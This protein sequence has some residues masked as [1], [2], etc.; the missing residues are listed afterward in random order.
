MI[1]KSAENKYTLWDYGEW[2]KIFLGKNLNEFHLRELANNAIKLLNLNFAIEED[3]N[4]FYYIHEIA[5][6][7]EKQKD[8]FGNWNNALEKTY[9]KQ[10]KS[11]L[12]NS[13]SKKD[14]KDVIDDII[15]DIADSHESFSD[16]NPE[17]YHCLWNINSFRQLIKTILIELLNS[18]TP[19]EYALIELKEDFNTELDNFFDAY[20]DLIDTFIVSGKKYKSV[21]EFS[22][23]SEVGK[24]FFLWDTV[25]AHI[26]I[27]FL[28]LG[29]QEYFGFCNYCGEFYIVHRKGKKIYCK[30]TCRAL[31]SREARMKKSK[32]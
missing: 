5:K 7:L 14:S 16:L 27:N 10:Q 8:I 23:N 25:I 2:L 28:S 11:Q 24:F 17:K 19:W 13:N 20:E 22:I 18:E 26:F 9:E 32:T 12:I 15:K 3:D 29:G 4:A 30:N 31:A 6:G 1:I 21:K